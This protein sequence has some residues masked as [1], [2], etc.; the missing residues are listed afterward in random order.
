M[1]PITPQNQQNQQ[2]TQLPTFKFLSYYF[3][4]QSLTANFC[5]QG[6]DNIIF[7]ERVTFAPNP[8]EGV[9][10]NP[11]DDPSL[12]TL[13]DRAL[14]LAFIV[15]GTSYYKAHPT[16]YIQLDP[17]IDDFQAFFFN[18]IYQEGLSQFAFENRLTRAYL[19]HFY[20][21]QG[22]HPKPPVSYRGKDILSLQSGGKDS[23]LTATMLNEQ[24][25][26][27]T[28]WYLSNNPSKTHP[29][30]IDNLS[31]ELSKPN[32]ASIAVRE[33][34]L[35]NLQQTGGLNGHV[36]VTLIVES[37]ALIQ[38]ILMNK[39]AVLT[40]IAQEG[41]EPSTVIGDLP[42]NH[43][44]AKT[45]ESEQLLSEYVKRYLSP[46]LII[47]SPIRHMS[48]LM[49]AEQF[50]KKCWHRYGFSF[51]SCNVANYRQFKDNSEL[52]W[53]GNC[54]KCAN[55]YLLFAPFLPP[56]SLSSLFADYDLFAREGLFPTFQGLLGIN[57]QQKPFE[58][59]GSV[60]ELRTAYHMKQPGYANLPFT[61]PRGNFDYRA[62]YPVQPSVISL[63]KK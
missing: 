59:V 34:D 16:Q 21:T 39:K 50:A 11:T 12:N 2:P 33:L 47:G 56:A 22:F 35:N 61:V 20:A 6:I 17:P 9:V 63:F 15:I 55:T 62:T 60:D 38:A 26:D 52:A 19:A 41:T 37:I 51:S 46:D 14:F 30:V 40:S 57:N 4:K 31:P 28:P 29:L 53:C 18:K 24:D 58:C 45:W 25:L 27:F 54:A 1:P 10:F 5:Y 49:V 32:P 36:P 23:I 7:T 44:W 43:Q 48:E 3:D 13:L 42:I 8:E